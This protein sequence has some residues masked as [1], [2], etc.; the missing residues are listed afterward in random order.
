MNVGVEI[1]MLQ[2]SDIHPHNQLVH[3]APNDT[4]NKLVIISSMIDKRHPNRQA[5]IWSSL[6]NS[7]S[8]E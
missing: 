1:T 3:I 4:K 5:I 8:L 2:Q 7:K 6:Q